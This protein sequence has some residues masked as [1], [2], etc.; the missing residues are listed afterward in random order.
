M[1]F[2]AVAEAASTFCGS[3][4]LRQLRKIR[5]TTKECAGSKKK[6]GEILISQIYYNKC[7]GSVRRNL[8]AIL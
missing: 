5:L 4:S 6:T 8:L 1:I 2:L 3:A 7:N